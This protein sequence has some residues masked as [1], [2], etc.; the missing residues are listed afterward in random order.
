MFSNICIN[1]KFRSPQ[2]LILA[3]YCNKVLVLNLCLYFQTGC[4]IVGY[5]SVVGQTVFVLTLSVMSF[6]QW[7]LVHRSLTYHLY[8]TLPK[9]VS[10]NI[11]IWIVSFVVY[12]PYF[13]NYFEFQYIINTHLCL[14]DI[15]QMCNRLVILVIR[16]IIYVPSLV[17]IFLC[18]IWTCQTAHVHMK[19]IHIQEKNALNIDHQVVLNTNRPIYKHY[20]TTLLIIT[21]FIVTAGPSFTIQLVYSLTSMNNINKTLL[22]YAEWSMISG[23]YLNV[24]ICIFTN[25]TLRETLKQILRNKYR[26]ICRLHYTEIVF[27]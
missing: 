23:S 18:N 15:L 20:K 22:F 3:L 14:I 12:T 13:F 10:I 1:T 21:G 4:N 6:D 2:W 5:T 17:I 26:K 19:Q 11:A 16:C 25:R 7:V 8:I 24:F 27:K 9:I